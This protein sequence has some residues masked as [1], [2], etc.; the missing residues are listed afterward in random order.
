MTFGAEYDSVLEWFIKTEVKTLHEI[1]EDST[2]WGNH[3]N[4]EDSP[5]KVVETGSIKKWCDNNIY[6]FTGNVDEWTQ[7]QNRSSYRVIRGGIYG[8]D[9]FYNAVAYRYYNVPGSHYPRIGFRA[10][11]YIK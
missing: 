8:N 2:A 4:T 1:T 3:W 11:L 6:D 10:A 5:R 9:G 7:E